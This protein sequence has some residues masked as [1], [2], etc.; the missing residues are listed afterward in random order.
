MTK[1]KLSTCTCQKCGH[2]W[3]PR[4]ANVR[5]CPNPECQSIRWDEKPNEK[6]NEKKDTTDNGK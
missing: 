4:I 5:K 1:Q 6:L 2:I 3:I